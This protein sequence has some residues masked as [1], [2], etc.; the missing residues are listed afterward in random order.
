MAP[1]ALAALAAAAAAAAA[2]Q[3]CTPPVLPHAI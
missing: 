1:A 3:L 2:V